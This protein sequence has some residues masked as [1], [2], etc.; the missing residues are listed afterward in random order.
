A[1]SSPWAHGS[2]A[3]W[4]TLFV[5]Q[6]RRANAWLPWRW[7]P[8]FA[9]GRRRTARLSATNS[10]RPSRNSFRSITMNPPPAAA[11][12]AWW[13]W[14]TL[15]RRNPI[16]RSHHER[17]ERS[18]RTPLGPGRSRG[19]RH[20]GG[21]LAGHRNRAGDFVLDGAGRGRGGRR[22]SP[23][24]EE[25]I[26]TGYGG[27]LARDGLGT[28]AQVGWRVRWRPRLAAQCER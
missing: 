9:S 24:R 5:A 12:I 4:A 27:S 8:R 7:I 3:R 14:L 19:S 17:E 18:L 23:R 15:C 2:S 6:K 11:R 16:P 25:H 13:S 20:A 10:P 1:I 21:S 28:A 22:Q 26:R